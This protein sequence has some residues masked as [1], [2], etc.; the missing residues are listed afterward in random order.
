MNSINTTGGSNPKPGT[1]INVSQRGP[2]DYV[3]IGGYR[4]RK[5]RGGYHLYIAKGDA[6]GKPSCFTT[7]KL[8]IDAMTEHMM[9]GSV[10]SQPVSL[11]QR[12]AKLEQELADLRKRLL[13]GG[14]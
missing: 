12:V 14:L 6:W 1:L 3:L 4:I 5:V 13:A 8:A 10:P 11:V 9:T 7:R 2:S